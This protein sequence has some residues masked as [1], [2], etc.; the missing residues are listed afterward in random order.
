VADEGAHEKVGTTGWEEIARGI[1]D[2][3]HR[4]GFEAGVCRGVS[5]LGDALEKYFPRG[6]RDRDELP[7]RP[8]VEPD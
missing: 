3:I 2:A 4:E 6:E 7:D 1:S 8:R 5:F